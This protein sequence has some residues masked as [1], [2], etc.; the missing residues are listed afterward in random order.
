MNAAARARLGPSEVLRLVDGQLHDVLTTGLFRES[1]APHFATAVFGVLDVSA[2]EFHIANAGHLPPIVRHANGPTA[3]VW[4]PPA[5]P[6]GLSTGRFADTTISVNPGNTLLFYTDGLV[7]VRNEDLE[8]GIATL[9][10]AFRQHGDNPDLEDL[11]DELLTS[12]GAQPGYG[13]DDVALVIIRL[14]AG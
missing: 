4:L 9:A 3:P 12:M 6:L 14:D 11:A 10:T 2:G 1:S 7:E 8:D 5:A 13:D